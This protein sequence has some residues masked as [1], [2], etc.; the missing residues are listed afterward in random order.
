M[1]IHLGWLMNL[2]ISKWGNSLA[3]RIPADYVR[4][5]GLKE[6]DSVQASLTSDGGISIHPVKWDRT[7]FAQE[8]AASRDTM[9]MGTSVIE[10]LRRGGAY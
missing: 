9:V 10:E 5:I 6:G 7:A 2:Q 4:S 8:V 1:Y 3:V